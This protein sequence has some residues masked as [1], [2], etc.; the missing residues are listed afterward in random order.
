[1]WFVL[2]MIIYTKYNLLNFICCITILQQPIISAISYHFCMHIQLLI[3]I[4]LEKKVQI[5]TNRPQ[6]RTHAKL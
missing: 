6:N 2:Y 1:M 3:D 4:R 5:I